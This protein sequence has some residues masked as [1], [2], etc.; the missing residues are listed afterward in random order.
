MSETNSLLNDM[1]ILPAFTGRPPPS[2]LQLA[3]FA[4]HVRLGRLGMRIPSK[5]EA[6]EFQSS[7]LA[8]SSLKNRIL[9]QDRE[10]GYIIAEQ[11]Q[12]KATVSKLNRERSA[13]EATEI[14]EQLPDSL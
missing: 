12:R 3:L 11:L 1:L 2:D 4:F 13:R 14:Y 6:S 10:Y 8:T 7:L 5:A 9:S